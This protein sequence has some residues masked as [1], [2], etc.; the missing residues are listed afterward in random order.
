MNLKQ[1]ILGAGLIAALGA[2]GAPAADDARAFLR[3]ASPPRHVTADKPYEAAASVAGV[4]VAM[5][6]QRWLSA[7][8]AGRAAL[9]LY[10]SAAEAEAAAEA[11]RT[12]DK[13]PALVA[14]DD[15]GETATIGHMS[16]PAVLSTAY[17]ITFTRCAA[18]AHIVAS[19]STREQLLDYA[20][21][22]DS[23]LQEARCPAQA[24]GGT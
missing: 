18:T 21:E 14:P 24:A 20:R 22:L 9:A 6:E 2:C 12:I 11:Y 3:A 4:P 8:G 23:L 19:D 10:A 1:C 17:F 16:P 15:L 7:N 13:A 5:A